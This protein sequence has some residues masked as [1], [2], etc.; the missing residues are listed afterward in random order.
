MAENEK[1][2]PVKEQGDGSALVAYDLGPD[3]LADAGEEVAVDD[4]KKKTTTVTL[5]KSNYKTVFTKVVHN[6]GGVFYFMDG[7]DITEA[8]FKELSKP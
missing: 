5:I 2:I 6:W 3:P 7:E 8:Q 1:D 4:G